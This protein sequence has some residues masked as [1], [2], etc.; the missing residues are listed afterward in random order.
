M[1]RA[2]NFVAVGVLIVLTVWAQR[3]SVE[4]LGPTSM[5]WN[6]VADVN[7]FGIDGEQWA[8]DLYIAITVWVMWIIR[9]AAVVGLLVKEFSRENVTRARVGG[10]R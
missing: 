8:E 2:F 9:G 10:F 5:L 1:S 6:M 7:S 4:L 3:V